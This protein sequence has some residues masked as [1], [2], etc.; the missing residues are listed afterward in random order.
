MI[1]F[2]VTS[3]MTNLTT[4]QVYFNWNYYIVLL[5]YHIFRKT[6]GCE[7]NFRSYGYKCLAQMCSELSRICQCIQPGKGDF[8]IYS[9]HAVIPKSSIQKSHHAKTANCES[10]QAEALPYVGVSITQ[11]S[12]L[13]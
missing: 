3:Q 12:Q 13:I 10:P 8:K 4:L 2:H 11:F 5:I 9:K 7:L 6:F 1:Y